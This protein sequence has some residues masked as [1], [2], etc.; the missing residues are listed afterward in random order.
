MNFAQADYLREW[1]TA[2]RKIRGA[3]RGYALAALWLKAEIHAARACRISPATA[4]STDAL[5]DAFGC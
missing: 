5:L 3:W 2:A 1:D 4:A